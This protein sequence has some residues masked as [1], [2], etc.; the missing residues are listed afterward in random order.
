MAMASCS[1]PLFLVLGGVPSAAPT[2]AAGEDASGPA[3]SSRRARAFS[4]CP[5][6]RACWAA[7]SAL[8]RRVEADWHRM[9]AAGGEEEAAAGGVAAET[10]KEKGDAAARLAVGGAA[11][12]AEA[13]SSGVALWSR[14]RSRCAAASPLVASDD[15]EPAVAGRRGARS[16]PS[17]SSSFSPPRVPLR[18]VWKPLCGGSIGAS[19]AVEDGARLLCTPH[20]PGSTS[21]AVTAAV[22]VFAMFLLQP[23][24]L[25]ISWMERGIEAHNGRGEPPRNRVKGNN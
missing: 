6:C 15:D 12:T 17:A 21:K 10:S 16:P 1:P 22:I 14:S 11:S 8:S 25:S 19:D 20:S 5:R 3:R 9:A 18:G 4:S 13:A 24:R 23:S 7:S 2:A